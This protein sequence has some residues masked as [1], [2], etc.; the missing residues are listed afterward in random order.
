MIPRIENSGVRSEDR[1]GH[2]TQP[3]HPVQRCRY[4]VLDKF[5]TALRQY[6]LAPEADRYILQ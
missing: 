5:L 1:D 4:I 2:E 3:R 6:S